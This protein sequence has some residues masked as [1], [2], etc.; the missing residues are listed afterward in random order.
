MCVTVLFPMK[1]SILNIVI[2][3]MEVLHSWSSLEVFFVSVIVSIFEIEQFVM[4]VIG[5][6]CDAINVILKNFTNVV[7]QPKCFD[8]NLGLSNGMFLV[9]L[10]SVL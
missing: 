9:I 5:S 3:T 8:V 4:F 10:A 1:K 2:I 7:P 6:N